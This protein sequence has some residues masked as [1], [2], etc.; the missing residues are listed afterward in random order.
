MHMIGQRLT[1]LALLAI[2]GI[3]AQGTS[4]SVSTLSVSLDIDIQPYLV[5]DFE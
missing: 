1:N 5:M 4:V 3:L 2:G